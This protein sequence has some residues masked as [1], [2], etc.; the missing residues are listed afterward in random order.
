VTLRAADASDGHADLTIEIPNGAV[1][2]V[3]AGHGDVTF[4]G[5]AGAANV[6]AARGDVKADNIAGGSPCA[7]GQRRF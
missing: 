5:L 3:T 6:N 1:P 4:E 2:T 7:H